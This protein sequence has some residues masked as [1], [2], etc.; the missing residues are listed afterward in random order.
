[1]NSVILLQVLALQIFDATSAYRTS[2]FW[3]KTTYS[4]QYVYIYIY[5]DA[6]K[7]ASCIQIYLCLL[8]PARALVAMQWHVLRNA[9]NSKPF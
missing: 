4:I 1:M 5:R 9:A 8:P 2:E 6:C 3:Q 7:I